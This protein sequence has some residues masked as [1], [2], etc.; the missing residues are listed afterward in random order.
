M[1]YLKKNFDSKVI[2][3][4]YRNP[5]FE[6]QYR[7]IN[8]NLVFNQPQNYSY[9]ED[10]DEQNQS[11][12]DVELNITTYPLKLTMIGNTNVGKTSIIK[13]FISNKYDGKGMST[14][15]VNCQDKK[16]KID[17]YTELNM[18]IWDTAGQER[19]RAI[20][21]GY[22]RESN[23]IFIVFDLSDQSSFDDLS[24]WMEEI[25]NSDIDDKICVKMLIGNKFDCENKEVDETTAKNF[26]EENNMKYLNVSAKDGV[27][28]ISMFEIMG[29]ACVN[30][31]KEKEKNDIENKKDSS[32]ISKKAKDANDSQSIRLKRHHNATKEKRC[33]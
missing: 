28:I 7:G 10:Y 31:L 22:L 23:G 27:N 24:L 19:F 12:S 17:P 18:Q 29:N 20:A 11:I 5:T 8:N 6:D 15:A 4:V 21:R 14:I 32:I 2:L 3:D 16:L 13:R 30:A 9:R 1:S 33:C 25:S 26:A